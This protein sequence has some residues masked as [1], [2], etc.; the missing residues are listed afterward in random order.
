MSLRILKNLKEISNT[1]CTTLSIENRRL[2]NPTSETSS[3][4]VRSSRPTETFNAGNAIHGGTAA[5]PDPAIFGMV[6]TLSTKCNADVLAQKILNS[7]SY[8]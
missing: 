7:K 8:V 1:N 2:S 6:D 5:I 3:K 4:K